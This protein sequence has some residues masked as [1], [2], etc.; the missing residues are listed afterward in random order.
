VHQLAG[1]LIQ[2]LADSVRFTQLGER[3][4]IQLHFQD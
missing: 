4:Q 2:R 3:P 1:Y